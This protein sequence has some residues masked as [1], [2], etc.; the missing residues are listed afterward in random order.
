MLILT[1]TFVFHFINLSSAI[2]C[3]VVY[4]F[5]VYTVV[6]FRTSW[7]LYM[8]SV[9]HLCS[10]ASWA[11]KIVKFSLRNV[12]FSF[13]LVLISPQCLFEPTSHLTMVFKFL[14]VD[15]FL[16]LVSKFNYTV[17]RE[18]LFDIHSLTF[19]ETCFVAWYW[20]N[21][22]IISVCAWDR[23]LIFQLLTYN[24]GFII[25]NPYDIVSFFHI[26][27][28]AVILDAFGWIVFIPSW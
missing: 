11:F 22:Q 27:F 16:P 19:V 14:N 18:H 26:D 25:Y 6:L 2:L 20:V 8:T 13:Y 3:H 21:F 7:F 23:N 5:V 24:W 12:V 28:D 10:F 9:S 4:V 15:R 17:I 1:I